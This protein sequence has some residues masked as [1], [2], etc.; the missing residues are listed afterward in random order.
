MPA[1]TELLQEGRYRIAPQ[2]A[3][4][5]T[6]YEAYDTVGETNVLVKEIFI[7]TGKVTTLSQQESIRQ[8]YAEKAK[9]LCSMKH[10]RLL[11]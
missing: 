5:G 9:R 1:N 6:V 2:S 8:S 11:R 10:D 3:N 7:R 4:N